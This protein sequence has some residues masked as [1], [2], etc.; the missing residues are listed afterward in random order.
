MYALLPDKSETTYSNFLQ[1]L[2]SLKPKLAPK[3]IM[4][5]FEKAMINSLEL[6]FPQT[7]IKGCFFFFIF[8]KA[9]T[10][11]FNLMGFSSNT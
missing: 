5:D 8:A 9:Y 1:Q 3:T 7:E 4:V 6:A 11:K 2:K 10:E